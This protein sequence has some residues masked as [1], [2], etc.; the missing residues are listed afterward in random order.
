MVNLREVRN[1]QS[2]NG[3]SVIA[4]LLFLGLKT[5]KLSCYIGCRQAFAEV[6]HHGAECRKRGESYEKGNRA[7][8]AES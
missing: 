3:F 7:P 1:S 5:V 4:V 8:N 6:W 2:N